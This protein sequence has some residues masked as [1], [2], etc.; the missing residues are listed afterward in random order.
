MD[1]VVRKHRHPIHHVVNLMEG[2]HVGHVHGVL[3]G[4]QL[5][6]NEAFYVMFVKFYALCTRS[7]ILF[8]AVRGQ[9]RQVQLRNEILYSLV[10]ALEV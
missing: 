8:I 3:R 10:G 5:L 1:H 9:V 4:S 7:L 2:V 6:V